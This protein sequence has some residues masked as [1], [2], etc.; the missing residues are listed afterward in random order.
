MKHPREAALRRFC[1]LLA[2]AKLS[3]TASRDPQ[4]LWRLHVED[5]LTALPLIEPGSVAELV[6]VGSGGG[7]P[8]VPLALALGCSAVLVESS[9]PKAAFL[10]RV[11][12]ETGLPGEVVHARSEEYGR[13][14]G[15]D[16]FPL[17]VARALAPPPASARAAA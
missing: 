12:A 15:R 2:G 11:L 10:Q 7:S 5:A 1:E 8:G 4:E 16:R 9:R 17:A 6:D 14:Q 3:V 13:G